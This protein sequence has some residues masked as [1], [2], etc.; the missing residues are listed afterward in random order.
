VVFPRENH[1]KKLKKFKKLWAGSHENGLLA[2]T[3][4]KEF[5]KI[6]S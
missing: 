4:G 1:E 3:I 5:A 6:H 2:L